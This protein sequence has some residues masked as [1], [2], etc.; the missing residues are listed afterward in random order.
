MIGTALILQQA[1]AA[2][3]PSLEKFK[4]TLLS[5]YAKKH[6]DII[7]KMGAILSAGLLEAGGRNQVVK[8]ASQ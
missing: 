5:V 6:E 4:K 8:L 7:C 3:E 2:S 1:N